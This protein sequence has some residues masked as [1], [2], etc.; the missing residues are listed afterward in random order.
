MVRNELDVPILTMT[1]DT[2]LEGVPALFEP[3]AFEDVGI[4][5]GGSETVVLGLDESGFPWKFWPFSR[6][7]E[8]PCWDDLYLIVES[9][10]GRRFVH[11][12]PL[13]I[14]GDWTISV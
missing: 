6:W 8:T 3:E 7:A 4:E 10:D 2:P 11:E 5:P 14:D 13:C 1:D 9:Q 12:P